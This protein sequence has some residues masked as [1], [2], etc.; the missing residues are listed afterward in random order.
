MIEYKYT[1]L[2]KELFTKGIALPEP[3]RANA[4]DAGMDL[5]LC[6][7]EP[8]KIFPGQSVKAQT[9]ICISMFKA[10]RSDIFDPCALLLPRSS[11]G[12]KLQNTIGLIDQDYQ[13][14]VFVKWENTSEE[15][16]VIQPN[17]RMV[18]I[19]IIPCL[20]A[21]WSEE[22]EFT[23]NTFRGMGDGSSGKG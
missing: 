19:I 9:G 4:S 11:Q 8:L 16:I 20:V 12:L 23:Q 15:V 1:E 22:K 10:L 14:G 7:E 17:E 3:Y 6:S 18:Q 13:E 2:A 5:R 21:N